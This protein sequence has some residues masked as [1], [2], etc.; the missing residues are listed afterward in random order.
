[1]TRLSDSQGLFETAQ[2]SRIFHRH[3]LE[4]R[5]AS[6][7][8][9]RPLVILCLKHLAIFLAENRLPKGLRSSVNPDRAV[10]P[11]R[12]AW[13]V[14]LHHIQ[15]NRTHQ[16]VL[17]VDGQPTFDKTSDGLAVPH[18]PDEERYQL[19]TDKGSRVMMLF[20]QT[21]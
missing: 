3:S 6:P 2:L 7:Y 5:A 10:P 8:I 17:L 4:Y 14:T 11:Y 19:T 12:D 15:G 18:G 9:L 13:H 20:A 21:K 16:S 1:M